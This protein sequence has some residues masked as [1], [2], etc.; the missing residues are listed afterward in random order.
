MRIWTYIWLFVALLASSPLA[1]DDVMQRAQT[2]GALIA[3]AAPAPDQ[4][5]AAARNPD[6][7]YSGFDVDVATAIAQR[8]QMP[9]RFVSPAWD[10]VLAGNW[11]GQW[12]FA[13]ASIT[14][15]AEREKALVFPA[16]Y[17][18][19][20]ASLVVRKGDT[21][22]ERPQDA[23]GKTIGVREGTT[24][25]DYLR[26]NLVIYG[27]PNAVTYLIQDPKIRTFADRDQVVKALVDRKVDA[28]VTSLALAENDIA[29]GQPIRI[30]QGFLFFEP[31]AVAVDRGDPAF[32]KAIA[33]AVRSLRADGTLTQLSEKW[34][35]I[36]VAGIVP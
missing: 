26:R 14:P 8:L 30:V 35:G 3:A 36:D 29:K 20:A 12:D 9:V 10:K 17:R 25:E 19:D 32:A 15:T 22:I 34:F 5:P 6:G 16:V 2:R 24:F 21:A 33:D 13:V 27:N 4:L 11:G 23:S 31:V 18:F 1:A 28:I 7:T